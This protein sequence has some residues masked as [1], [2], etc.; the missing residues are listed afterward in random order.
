MSVM[1]GGKLSTPERV[2][3]LDDF[4]NFYAPFE[5]QTAAGDI[6][7]KG[8]GKAVARP[9]EQRMIAEWAR[10]A[11]TEASAGRT[12]VGL[13][14]ALNWH[15]QGGIAGFCDDLLAYVSGLAQG[16]SCRAPTQAKLKDRQMSASELEQLYGWLDQY[17]PFTYHHDDGAAADSMA[18]DLIFKGLGKTEADAATQEQILNFAQQLYTELSQ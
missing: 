2:K 9:A 7:F 14:L 5:A 18:I 13:G 12:D 11:I 6:T 3:Q 4:V 15:R 16:T 17:A 1:M 10:L 8:K